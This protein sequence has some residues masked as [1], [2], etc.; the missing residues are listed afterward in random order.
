MYIFSLK[1]KSSQGRPSLSYRYSVHIPVVGTLGKVNKTNMSFQSISN[2]TVKKKLKFA[3]NSVQILNIPVLILILK[4]AEWSIHVRPVFLIRISFHADPDPGSQ[5]FPY[6][7]G[8]R[9][10]IF[11]S[12]PDPK[13]V[14]I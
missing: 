7:S 5:K 13:G 12:D 4:E 11:Y 3:E 14:K 9:T 6:G 2:L 10:L 8:S 1:G